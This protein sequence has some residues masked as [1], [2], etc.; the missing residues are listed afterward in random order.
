MK[1]RLSDRNDL[2]RK[3]RELESLQLQQTEE[4]QQ[5]LRDL[6]QTFSPSN[7]I[8][9]VMKN[10]ISSPGL[11]STA[12]DTAISAGA[13]ILGRKL[14]TRNSHSI[15][16][17]VAGTAVQFFLTNLVRNKIPG[18]KQQIT[19]KNGAEHNGIEH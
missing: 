17:K 14:V 9:T 18:I 5:S 8:R 15:I 2:E 6:G 12:L 11:Q 13:G 3:I 1:K 19:S 16:R 10:V 7:M 4:L